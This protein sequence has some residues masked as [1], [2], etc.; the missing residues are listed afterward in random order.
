MHQKS[1]INIKKRKI[2]ITNENEK[3]T[4]FYEG[5]DDQGM[6]VENNPMV[7]DEATLVQSKGKPWKEL[8]IGGTFGLLLAGGGIYASGIGKG[9]DEGLGDGP[10]RL[11]RTVVADD[12]VREF[13]ADR[14]A[15]HA[16]ATCQQ[17]LHFM[18]LTRLR[19]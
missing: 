19:R 5:F 2:M 14:A 9:A 1:V 6:N 4:T 3:N 16:A 10:E 18:P 15:Q 8:S 7:Q 13:L 12:E 17:H 11:D